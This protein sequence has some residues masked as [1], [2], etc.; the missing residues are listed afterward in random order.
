MSHPPKNVFQ[1]IFAFPLVAL[2]LAH[3]EDA[4]AGRPWLIVG[5]VLSAAV[6]IWAGG[7]RGDTRNAEVAITAKGTNEADQTHQRR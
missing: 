5:A 2:M 3:T 7:H 4:L 1:V 6:S